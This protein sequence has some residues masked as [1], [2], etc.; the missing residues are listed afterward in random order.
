MFAT[1]G[2]PR[3]LRTDNGPQFTSHLFAKFMKDWDISHVTSSPEHHVGNGKVERANQTVRHILEKVNGNRTMFYAG[4]LLYRNTPNDD[5]SPVQRLMSRRTATKLPIAEKLLKPRVVKEEAVQENIRDRQRKY[6]NHFD[7]RTRNLEEI[8]KNDTIRVRVGKQWR[9]ARL[10]N[11]YHPRSYEIENE[12]GNII[13]RNRRDILK[14][15]E[16]DIFKR[17]NQEL[18]EE[19][20][21]DL[22]EDKPP[23]AEIQPNPN[24]PP[25]P[26]FNMPKT[27]LQTRSGRHINLPTKFKDYKM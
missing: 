1:H 3:I 4:L 5:V 27:P 14:T 18:P 26:N 15:R 8:K 10:I 9:P 21:E 11:Q 16:S 13:R 24:L 7:N 22:P 17:R 25:N 19:P 20:P 6:K 23:E 2:K 12:K